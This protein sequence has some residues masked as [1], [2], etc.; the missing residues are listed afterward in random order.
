MA[1]DVKSSN[2]NPTKNVVKVNILRANVKQTKVIDTDIVFV[3][4]DGRTV[5]IRDGAVQS[6]LDNGFAVEFSDGALVSGQELLQSA[7]T[8]ELSSIAL[9]GPQAS[10]NDGV[11]VVQAPQAT[12]APEVEKSTSRSGLSTWLAVGTPVVGGVLAGVLGGGGG[13]STTPNNNSGTVKPAMPVINV[14]ANDDKVNATEKAAGVTVSGISDASASVA[15]NWGNTTKTVTA[16]SAGRWSAS[17]ASGEVPADAAGTTV[18][19]TVKSAAGV[20][21]DPATKTVQIDTTLPGSPVIAKVAGDGII[22]PVEKAA[23]ISINGT[24]EAGSTVTVVFGTVSKSVIA[25]IGGSWSVNFASTELPEPGAYAIT[26]TVRDVNGNVSAAPA[27]SQVTVSAAVDVTGQIIAGPLVAGHGLS[28]DIFLANGTLL[29]SGVKVNADG[30]FTVK[31]LLAG[32]GDVIIAKVVDATPDADY[33]D[34]TTRLPTDLNAELL[35]VKVLESTS[36]TMNVNPLTTIA[37][38]KAGLAADGSGTVAN[39]DVAKNANM[40]VAQAFGIPGIDI[41]TTS[42]VATNSD[43]FSQSGGLSAGEKVGVVLAALSGY[44]K[45][46]KGD[47][48]ATISMLSDQLNVQGSKGELANNGQVALMTGAISAEDQVDGS[49]QT[50]ISNTVAESSLTSQ[51]TIGAVATDNIISGSEASSLTLSGKVSSDVVNVS[52]LLGTQK[53]AAKINGSEWSYLLSAAELAALGADGAKII[54][55]EAELANAT[56][57]TSSRLVALKTTPPA[58]PTLDAVSGD[59]GI[60]AAEKAA[61][62]TFTGRS[63]L[64]STVTL[65]LGSI[66][67]EALVDA[68]GIWTIRLLNTEIPSDGSVPVS[69]SAK[70]AFGNASALTIPRLIQIDTVAPGKPTILPVTGDNFISPAEKAAGIQIQ[71][72]AEAAATINLTFGSVKRTTTAD[73]S[74]NWSVGLLGADLPSDGKQKF[75]VTQSDSAGNESEAETGEVTIDANPPAK[76]DILSVTSDNIIN[77]TEKNIGVTV[78]GTSEPNA[79]VEIKWGVVTRSVKALANG[80]WS[81]T[82]ATAQIPIDGASQITATATDASGNKSELHTHNLSIDTRTDSVIIDP[83]ATDDVINAA[84]KKADLKITGT[85]EAGAKVVVKLG[86][87]EETSSADKD[88]KWTVVFAAAKIPGD[89]ISTPVTAKATDLAGNESAETQRTIRINSSAPPAP[90]IDIVTKDGTIDG[91]EAKSPVNVTGTAVAGTKVKVTWGTTTREA[92]VLANGKW[93]VTFEPTEIPA[94]GASKIV[95]I[96]RNSDQNESAPTERDVTIDVGTIPAVI[97]AIT[98]D[99]KINA[100][101]R[102]DGV[103]VT[104]RAEAGAKVSLVWGAVTKETVV[105]ADGKWSQ[106]FATAEIPTSGDSFITATPT[107]QFGNVGV[108]ERRD[109]VIDTTVSAAIIDKVTDDNKVSGSEKSAALGVRVTGTAERDSKVEVTWGG[110][111]KEVTADGSGVWRTSF[112]TNEIPGDGKTKI[113]AKVTDVAGNVSVLS[114]WDVEIDTTP[115]APPVINSPIA[116]DDIIN[117]TELS[118]GVNVSGTTEANATVTIVWREKLTGTVIFTTTV[119]ADNN[120]NWTRKFT[121]AEIDQSGIAQIVV[122]ASDVVGNTSDAATK[123]VTF[124]TGRPAK[125]ILD[126]LTPDD[127]VNLL[128]VNNGLTVTGKGLVGA[129]INLTWGAIKATTVVQNDGNWAVVLGRGVVPPDGTPQMSVTQT[130]LEG[131]TSLPTS[132]DITVDISPPAVPV[133]TTPIAID[134]IINATEKAAGVTISGTAPISTKM[135]VAFGSEVEEIVSDASGN[136]TVTFASSRIGADRT[137]VVVQ[138]QTIDALGNESAWVKKTV[139]VDTIV[140]TPTINAPIAGDGIVNI[141]ERNAG[142]TV[143][144][145]AAA[146]ADVSVAW[147]TTSTK[148]VKANGAGVWLAKFTG[149]DINSTGN[150]TISATQ[151]D[152]AGNVSAAASRSVTVDTSPLAAPVITTPI[153]IDNVINATEKTAGVVVTGTG[154]VSSTIEVKIGG[155]TAKPV[156][157]NASGAWSVSFAGNE[158]PDDATGVAIEARTI[159][160]VGN[161]SGWTSKLVDIDTQ[162]P[163]FPAVIGEIGGNSVINLAEKNAV[164]GVVVSGVAPAG[165]KVDVKIGNSIKTDIPVVDGEWSVPFGTGEIPGDATGVIVEGRSYDAAGNTSGWTE[166]TTVDIDTTPDA[167]P[168]LPVTIA[169]DNAINLT[170]KTDGVTVS[171]SALITDK[172]QFRIDGGAVKDATKNGSDIWSYTFA[173]ADIPADKTGVLIEARSVDVNGNVSAWVNKS[174]TIDTVVTSNVIINSPKSVINATDLNFAQAWSG[175]VELSPSGK[176]PSTVKVKWGDTAER[177]PTMNTTTGEW[178]TTYLKADLASEV[179]KTAQFTVTTTDWAGNVSTISRAVTIDTVGQT[180]VISGMSND[181]GALGDYITDRNRVFITGTGE[182]KTKVQMTIGTVNTTVNV[183]AFGHWVSPEIDLSKTAVGGTVNVSFVG[184]D[185]FNQTSEGTASKTIQKVALG[186]ATQVN[187]SSMNQATGFTIAGARSNDRMEGFTTGDI[188]GDGIKDLIFSSSNAA[189][190]SGTVTGAV[191]V[192]Y[193]KT[194]WADATN[195][196]LLTMGTDKGWVLQGSTSGIDA[197]GSSVGF[198]GDLNGDGY[199]ELIAGAMSAANAG[200]TGAGA[201]YIVWG[202]ANPLGVV[203][204]SRTVLTIAPGAITSNQGFVFRGEQTNENLGNAV[205]G[206]SSNIVKNSANKITNLNSDFNGDG[207][208]DFFIASRYFDRFASGT[209]Q[210]AATDVGAVM[211][212]FGR[213]DLDYG[214]WNQDNS[215]RE[216]SIGKLTADKGFIIR[217]ASDG[218]NAGHSISSAGD[219]NGDGLTD[220]LIGAPNVDRGGFTKAGAAYV[221]YGKKTS[222]GVTWSGLTPDPYL[223]TRNILDLA[224]LKSSDGFMIQGEAQ[225]GTLGTGSTFGISVEGLGDINGDGYA[226]IGIGAA[227]ALPGNAGKAY[228]IFGSA[229]GQ[230]AKDANDLQV[231]DSTTMTASQGFILQGATGWLGVSVGAAGDVNGD[232]HPDFIVSAPFANVPATNAGTSYIIYGRDK[233]IQ[234]GN[235]FNGQA[236]INL[237]SASFGPA[238][239][240]SI[241]GRG[242]LDNLGNVVTADSSVIAPGDLNNDGID[243]LFINNLRADRFSRADNGEAVFIYGARE[244]ATAASRSIGGLRRIGTSDAETLN[245][246]DG[247]DYISGGGGADV[248]RGFA[249]ND[250][251]VFDATGFTLIDGGTGAD[252]LAMVTSTGLNFDLSKLLL[253]QIRDIEIIDMKVNQGNNL[254]TVTEQSLIDLSSTTDIL[255]VLGDFSDKVT[256]AGFN[257][258]NSYTENGITFNIYKSGTAELWTQLGVFVDITTPPPPAAF[259]P[260]AFSWAEHAVLAA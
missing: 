25:D 194:S 24:A 125:P 120:G 46:N 126:V 77:A 3:L 79:T 73:A 254:L 224:T 44:D 122:T 128:E 163:I 48:K 183:D 159:D 104:G 39:A 112:A 197:L 76:P 91:L 168:V 142:V 218:D 115:P 209:T 74:G 66:S 151:T 239:G 34:E 28:V 84:E 217:G 185:G 10:A 31:N 138:A 117:L 234:F 250:T 36:V 235:L 51:V 30:S 166:M 99:N 255:K 32:V 189:N 145:A 242:N 42:V 251:I 191:T 26:A 179:N 63:E 198:I 180:P 160:S 129:T 137:D 241:N 225:L 68:T 174:V 88:G 200:A 150:A 21:S 134:N 33:L 258:A 144:G 149:A 247:G 89:I 11:I 67:K 72:K 143:T 127:K 182:A 220:L 58:I 15:V 60:N 69:V 155:G 90:V 52:I 7:G 136:W 19:A 230:G 81:A 40:A 139:E 161:Q 177:V 207:L 162:A 59:N 78:R 211:V 215:T 206:I 124:N 259:V 196:D 236:V 216:M 4:E 62:V 95:A 16:D 233:G 12:V 132:R 253:G 232:G 256:A 228:V 173:T 64:G 23:G 237:A 53:F 202:S 167:A 172:V 158:I 203:Q 102:N 1:Q 175:K 229:S 141:T 45:I 219:V 257:F 178:S 108:P 82:F 27:T 29:I 130:N 249:G 113:T 165:F 49:L 116:T 83:I 154:P 97:D 22:G 243:D 50:I 146:N 100:I 221:I 96:V 101:E 41:S 187:L 61:G 157:S 190:I 260:Q 106:F 188:N 238:E 80:T 153:A 87:N 2:I 156:T 85:A 119:S 35:A 212:V 248:L 110:T 223:P 152:A 226:D 70:D 94:D 171:T 213:S 55:A 17:F 214:S 246:S 93:T 13:S 111:V 210:T 201:A 123:E 103:T 186:G 170:E 164:G 20:S 131:N 9:T 195:V 5:F 176:S 184:V 199:G 47:S 57:V 181:Y 75:T 252:T 245:G 92:N 6:L 37:A 135:K 222:E 133:I 121:E 205:L 65:K 118:A 8:A 148:T 43:G 114:N 86:A 240:F 140:A 231:L 109:F 169:G 204:N 14:I 105:G 54:I 38:I 71:G 147:G 227:A 107:D 18:S 208:A 244:D 193:G 98:A 192:L 56:K